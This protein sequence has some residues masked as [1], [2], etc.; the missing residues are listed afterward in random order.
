MFHDGCGHSL[1]IESVC[2]KDWATFGSSI[3][4]NT[5][6]HFLYVLYCF[7]CCCEDRAERIKEL[8]EPALCADWM[9]LFLH[10]LNHWM[11]DMIRLACVS[12]LSLQELITQLK[13]RHSQ[14]SQYG[15][16]RS[17]SPHFCH[18]H[19][20]IPTLTDSNASVFMP[21]VQ[22]YYTTEWNCLYYYGSPPIG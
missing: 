17:E 20:R 12:Q 13:K 1:L 4:T 16:Y 21:N 2:C 22:R 3:F 11:R 7:Y 19:C 8:K 9:K 18:E 15:P 14:M 10:T 6:V 5:H